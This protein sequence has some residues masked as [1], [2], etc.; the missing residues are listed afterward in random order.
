MDSRR[1]DARPLGSTGV[2]PTIVGL[3]GEGVLRTFG[4]DVQAAAVI[5]AAI[6][7]GLTYF[8]SARA[9]AGSE[10]YYGSSLGKR[11]ERIF[12]TSKAHDRDKRGALA[13]LDETLSNMR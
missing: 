9:Y 12:L 2:S 7:E 3:G 1:I 13:M 5:D 10:R 11:R 4:Y 8:D 6:D